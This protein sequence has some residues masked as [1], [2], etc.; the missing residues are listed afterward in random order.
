MVPDSITKDSGCKPELGKF[1]LS[2]RED[3]HWKAKTLV[4]VHLVKCLCLEAWKTLL[5]KAVPDLVGGVPTHGR[6]AGID[7][8]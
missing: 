6:D 2:T 5:D 3:S 8:L 1:R 4:P 7:D